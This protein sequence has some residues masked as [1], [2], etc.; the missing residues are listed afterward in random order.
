[1]F[2][3]AATAIAG[4]GG[5]IL[6]VPIIDQDEAA[7]SDQSYFSAAAVGELTGD[8]VA[9]LL[10]TRRGPG[11]VGSGQLSV[12]QN[13]GAGGLVLVSRLAIGG[14][15]TSV[16]LEDMTG[17]GRV[18]ALITDGAA[19]T[20]SI[21]AQRDAGRF[22]L[23]ET[24]ATGRTPVEATLA[25]VTGDGVADLLVCNYDH[26][27]VGLHEGMAGGGFARV[28]RINVGTR[29]VQMAVVDVDGDGDLDVVTANQLSEDLSVALNDGGVFGEAISVGPVE[30][31]TGLAGGD[32][33]G[34]GLPEFVVAE[35]SGA[36][37]FTNDG[38]RLTAG[39]LVAMSGFGGAEAVLLAD[40]GGDGLLDLAVGSNSGVEVYAG[41][42]ASATGLAAEGDL[43][44]LGVGL[45]GG[46]GRLVAADLSTAGLGDDLIIVDAT[47]VSVAFSSDGP[48]TGGPAGLVGPRTL[49]TG[50]SSASVAGEFTGDGVPDVLLVRDDGSYLL[51]G[52]GG[53]AFADPTRVGVGSFADEAL[54]ARLR[55]GSGL[56]DVLLVG[57]TLLL[58]RPDGAGGFEPHIGL[59]GGVRAAAV[60]DLDGDGDLDVVTAGIDRAYPLFNDGAGNLSIGP[61]LFL[62][63]RGASVDIGDV[64]GD[65]V[66]DIVVAAADSGTGTTPFYVFPGLGGGAFGGVGTFD[67][68]LRLGL[69][70]RTI[71]VGADRDAV[72]L[73]QSR[74]IDLVGDV[75]FPTSTRRRILITNDP[76]YDIDVLDVDG[77]GRMD[78]TLSQQR[79]GVG[80]WRQGPG[81]SFERAAGFGYWGQEVQLTDATGDGVLDAL[82][83]FGNLTALA[84]GR[85]GTLPGCAADLD[86][87]GRATLMDFLQFQNW[88]DAGDPRADVDGDGALTIFDFLRFQD[89]FA[90]GC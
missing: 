68:G 78:F 3:C 19:S 54:A 11:G 70:V 1:M 45:F 88:F 67:L 24:I 7:L 12:Y 62:P 40:F 58:L 41:S 20:L 82:L 6:P 42:V 31:P 25:D 71:D 27:F 23:V 53:G 72:L 26:Y 47:R 79:W 73:V 60:G 65:G 66:A 69:S 86:G 14:D 77:D 90:L 4:Q 84:V 28:V 32:L 87:D 76:I 55:P 33:N 13:D 18:D 22:E 57:S 83:G 43:V 80:V 75:L 85:D 56:D 16:L 44:A 39:P 36:R 59:V 2:V 48:P 49:D 37:L 61:T 63:R 64:T 9:D 21:Y 89:V 50:R 30:D 52:L 35:R 10:V 5:P 46:A 29:P 81:A 15:P 51:A 17:D 74:S 38:G 34:D 8:G